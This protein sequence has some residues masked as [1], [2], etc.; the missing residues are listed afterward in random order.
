M[1]IQPISTAS[2]M[3]YLTPED[4]AQYGLSA[5]ELTDGHTLELTKNAFSQ[6]GLPLQE[7]LEI[8]SFPDK[9]GLLLFIRIHPPRQTV[10]AFGEFE[11]LLAVAPL[12]CANESNSSL[13]RWSGHLWLV[14][15]GD[16]PLLSEFADQESDDPY[17]SARL[18][19]YGTSLL[20]GRVFSVL[21]EH[22]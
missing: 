13:Y 18:S 10:W 2:V 20:T 12:L 9:G 21:H 11:A 19:E 16:C 22:F 15:E 6:A 7:P 3:V 17:I 1:T 8:E 14:W 4:L 5:H